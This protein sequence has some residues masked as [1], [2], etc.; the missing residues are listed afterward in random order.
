M[1]A[2]TDQLRF[3]FQP[4]VNLSTGSVAAM[5]ILARP[6]PGAV[7]VLT[8]ARRCPDLD[9][10][11]AA[12]AV[13]AASHQETL[14]PLHVNVFAGTVA[15][16][17]RLTSLTKAV[18]E[19]GRRPWEVTL[20]IGGPFL[21]VPGAA[22]LESVAGLRD[23]GFR[24]CAD[25]VGDGDLPLRLLGALAPDL[26]KLDRSLCAGLDAD[27][28]RQAVVAAMRELCERTGGLLAI[29]GVETER[30]YAAVRDA[31]VQLAQGHLFA[32]P[33]RRPAT[34]VYLPPSVS[35]VVSGPAAA[36]YRPPSGP[37]VAQFLQPAALLP[38]TASAGAVRSHLTGFP[39]VSGVLLVDT[40]GVPV[41]AIDRDRFLLSLSGRYGHALYADR[42]ALR[43]ADRP[44]TVG[45]DATAW[46]VLDVIAEGDRARTGDDV[47][48]V[49]ERGRCM[50]VVHLADILRALAES[51]VEEAARLNP[52]TRLPGSDEVNAEVDRRIAEGRAFALSWLD[53]DGFKQ[54]ND[55]AGFAAG[56]ELIRSVGR[57]LAGVAA[58]EPSCRV[59]HIGGD[60]F[61]VLA[62]PDGLGPFAA[63]LLDV[64]WEAGGRPVT[65][66][67][68]TVV[69]PPGS[70]GGHHEA[71]AALAPL[72][73]EAKALP[74]ASW[75]VGRPGSA[76]TEV[77]RGA[78][79]RVPDP[80]GP[81]GLRAWG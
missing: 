64:A 39:E 38:M 53:V 45:A 59:G 1:P 13:R 79:A 6:E 24:I 21:H 48:V 47:A 11:L 15:E 58:D 50:G 61:L 4:V 10:E 20:D 41:R 77:R 65:L 76:G 52:L 16:L 49:D 37:P 44:R 55:G 12:L 81:E 42:P 34:D 22:L 28:G 29:E 5:E 31:G 26:V 32:P 66:S 57:T 68:A 51:R 56:D 73:K 23:E 2:W 3:A 62:E 43:L 60:D 40:D 18:H 7:D 27:R 19:V 54:V 46:Q 35:P 9:A 78:V 72:K 70:V 14:L 74:G 63:A 80:A 71:A 33:A 17:P 67:L 36:T 8:S 30:Q 25:G 75:V 69:C